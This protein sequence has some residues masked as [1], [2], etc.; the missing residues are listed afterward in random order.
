[1][2]IFNS[3]FYFLFKWQRTVNS[4]T[5]TDDSRALAA[6][7]AFSFFQCINLFSFVPFDSELAVNLVPFSIFFG[8][9]FFMFY[10]NNRYIKIVRVYDDKD[11]VPHD[12]MS[13]LYVTGTLLLF[14]LNRP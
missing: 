3:F 5:S 1:M 6:V 12:V 8:I 2:F 9:N 11:T 7:I 13:V 4:V 10:F 14:F